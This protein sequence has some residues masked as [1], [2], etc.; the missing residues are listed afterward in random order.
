MGRAGLAARPLAGEMDVSD[1]AA[2]WGHVPGSVGDTMHFHIGSEDAYVNL[3]SVSSH[4]FTS[5]SSHG[6]AND[7]SVGLPTPSQV[8]G[9]TYTFSVDSLYKTYANFKY[10]F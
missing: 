8:M 6:G 9:L 1:L 5:V 2:P 7:I 10:N 4:N 3:P